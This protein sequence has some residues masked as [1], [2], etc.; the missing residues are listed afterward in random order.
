VRNPNNPSMKITNCKNC[1]SHVTGNFCSNCGQAVKLERINKHYISHEILHLLH[2]EKGFF[3]TVKELFKRP[4]NSIREFINTD[5]SKHIKPVTFLILTSLFY[6]LITHYFHADE[7]NNSKE[8]LQFGDSSV[9]GIQEWVNSHYG[10]AN[11]IMGFF[12]AICV[13]LFFRKYQ[14][15][16]FEISIVLCFVMGQG[17]LM[18]AF[19]AFFVGVLNEQV[20]KILLLVIG[21]SYPTWAIGQFFDGKKVL[22]YVKAFLAYFFGY[23]LFIVAII[24]VGVTIDVIVKISAN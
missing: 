17:M 10:Y 5:R 9:V 13:K 8:N 22:S 18:L 15:N 3:F 1:E 23:L 4:G 6:A 21:F 11:M 7:I 20:Y 12:I 2:L 16:F 14:Y 24:L 19:E